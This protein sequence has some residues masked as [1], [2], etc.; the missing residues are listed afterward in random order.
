MSDADMGERKRNRKRGREEERDMNQHN[1]WLQKLGFSTPRKSSLDMTKSAMKPTVLSW[2]IDTGTVQENEEVFPFNVTEVRGMIKR[3]GIFCACCN[4]VFT[5]ADFLI[6]GGRDGDRPYE[7]IY[8]SRTHDSLL[9]YLAEA[10][11]KPGEL[12]LHRSN[13]IETQSTADDLHDDA[14]MICAD[15]GDLLCCEKCNS[16]YHQACMGMKDVPE[17]SWYCP[18]CVCKVCANPANKDDDLLTCPQCEKKYHWECHVE[19]QD[20]RNFDLNVISQTPFCDRSCKEVYDKLTR[21]MVGKRNELDEGFSWTL[22]H[23]WSDGFGMFIGDTYL[24]TMCHSKLGVARS[25][26]EECFEPIKDRYTG[27]KV[28]PSVVYNCGSNFKRLDFGG[29]YTAVLEKDDEIITV[30]SLRIH[31]TKLAEMPFIATSEAQRSKGMCKKLMV[32]IESA[33]YNLNIE[34]IVIPSVPERTENWIEGYGF[35]HLHASMKREIM[36]HNTLTFHDSVRLQ[37]IL[38]TPRRHRP[39]GTFPFIFFHK[40]FELLHF[41]I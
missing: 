22:L 35:H 29:F 9:S 39:S 6:H 15:G 33:L 1:P 18:Y 40:F 16:T 30:A 7:N 36:L 8:A 13:N 2:L 19:M 28:I 38:R 32:A 10:W 41:F 5:A 26:M 31:G 34:N 3:E 27:I 4:K 12:E 25:L 14:C 24:R 21:D 37:K 20:R 17:G 23:R 11:N